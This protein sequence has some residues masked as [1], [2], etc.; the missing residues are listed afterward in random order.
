MGVLPRGRQSYVGDVRENET[1][2]RERGL[3]DD[4]TRESRKGETKGRRHSRDKPGGRRQKGQGTV[5]RTTP[6]FKCQIG[7]M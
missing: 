6:T 3:P 4:T 2:G 1:K 7:A 5:G